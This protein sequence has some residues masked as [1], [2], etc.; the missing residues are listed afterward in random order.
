MNRLA[1]VFLSS[2]TIVGSMLSLLLTV[3]PAHAAESTASVSDNLS[4]EPTPRVG[5]LT[6]VRLSQS[7]PT[8][9]T[10]NGTEVQAVSNLD[11]SSSEET[12]MLEFTDEQ[13]NAAVQLFGCDCLLC[14]NA[15]RQMRGLAPLAS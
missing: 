13:S 10:S 11:P 8:A 5:R 4:C 15:V 12:P 1:L 9:N 7:A 14:I 3:N 2:P 6:C